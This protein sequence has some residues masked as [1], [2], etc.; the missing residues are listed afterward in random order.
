MFNKVFDYHPASLLNG[1]IPKSS[2]TAVLYA[3]PANNSNWSQ[4]NL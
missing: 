1:D 2:D 3:D 4:E